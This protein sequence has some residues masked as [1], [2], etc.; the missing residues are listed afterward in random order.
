[1]AESEKINSIKLTEKYLNM[2]QALKKFRVLKLKN[3]FQ[4][5]DF[6]TVTKILVNKDTIQIAKLLIETLNKL[7]SKSR[8]QTPFQKKMQ[9]DHFLG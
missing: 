9:I 5:S 2:C 6:N 4:N 7:I 1:M 3:T 8:D